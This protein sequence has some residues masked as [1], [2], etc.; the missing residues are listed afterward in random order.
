MR[1]F[2]LLLTCFLVAWS[3]ALARA[4]PQRLLVQRFEALAV[5]D[6][7]AR[8]LEEAVVLQLGRREGISVVTPAE[9][10]QTVEFA[11]TQAELGCDELDQCMVEVQ[12]KLSVQRLIAGKVSKLGSDYI[13]ALGL[14]DLASK[15]VGNRITRQAGT[16]PA[17]LEAVPSGLDELLGAAKASLGF[18]LPKGQ[19]LKLAVMPLSARGVTGATADAMTQILSAELNGIEGISVISRDD[20]AAM[21]E[22]V[23]TEGELGCTDNMECIVEIGA[24]LGL[25]KLVTGTVGKV[26]DTFVI[27]L[28]LVDIRKADVENRVL[29]SFDGAADE[30]KHAIKL[31]AYELVGVE[32]KSQK[33]RVDFTFNV[34]DAEVRLGQARLNLKDSQLGIGD[35]EPG[36][37]S[38]RVIADPDD[39]YPLQTDVYVSPHGNNVRTFRV[40]ERPSA[41]YQK[42]WVWTITGAVVAAGT[43]TAVIV[44]RDEPSTVS[45]TATVR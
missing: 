19:T 11:K 38:L 37:Y 16:F 5:E 22:K 42:W 30:L 40:A 26:A 27:S 39:Y 45:G 12:K 21:L 6:K 29:E 15:T 24:S 41:W 35:L 18:Q 28:Q 43:T 44:T 23:Q 25:S 8:S 1:R 3:S 13:L 17:L 4:E 9:M 10:E 36:R 32:Y 7:L 2:S 20:I 34:E 33:G 14:V 31:T